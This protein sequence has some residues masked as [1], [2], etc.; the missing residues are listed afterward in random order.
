MK[1]RKHVPSPSLFFPINVVRVRTE[2]RTTEKSFCR[3]DDRL[4]LF[5]IDGIDCDRRAL[6]RPVAIV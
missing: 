6:G 5:E 2:P 1:I 4:A 3:D